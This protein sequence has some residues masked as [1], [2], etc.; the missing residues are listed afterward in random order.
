MSATPAEMAPRLRHWV[1]ESKERPSAFE[2]FR[3]LLE[4]VEADPEQDRKRPWLLKNWSVLSPLE[5]GLA[6]TPQALRTLER[7]EGP[8][9]T[10]PWG[11]YINGIQQGYMMSIGTG[12]LA[13]A[14]VLYGRPEQSLAYVHTL[15]D[16]LEMQ[17][18]G[19]ISEMSPD[20]GC[21]VQAWSGY[22]VAWP[23][24]AGIFGVRPDAFHRRIELTPSFPSTWP[25]AELRGLRVGTN[26]FDLRWDGGVLSVASGE[27]GWDI[28]CDR[29]P[30]RLEPSLPPPERD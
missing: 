29:V 17:M 19:A 6:P 21:F 4:A 1:E 27:P 11:V 22:G 5:A 9:F 3:D 25:T 16:T 20:W 7:A 18:P 13:V 14:E 10:G 26:R 8:E 15:T 28:R 24:V 23:V 2:G 12:V 30:M